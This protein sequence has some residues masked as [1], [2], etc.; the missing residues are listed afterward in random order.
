MRLKKKKKRP[1]HKCPCHYGLPL[2][3]AIGVDPKDGKG[4]INIAFKPSWPYDM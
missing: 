2:I 4:K 1:V 3:E